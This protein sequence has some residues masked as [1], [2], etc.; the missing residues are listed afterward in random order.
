MDFLSRQKLAQLAGVKLGPA[1]SIT[2]LDGG[3]GPS[4][5]PMMAA[6]KMMDAS[7]PIERGELTLITAVQIVYALPEYATCRAGP[8]DRA[9]SGAI[10]P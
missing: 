10:S 2:E 1:V 4:P 5:M 7:A 8:A 6:N 3:G 9:P